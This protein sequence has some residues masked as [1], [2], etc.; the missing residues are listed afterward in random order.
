MSRQSMTTTFEVEV[1][2]FDSKYIPFRYRLVNTKSKGTDHEQDWL[3]ETVDLLSQ[4]GMDDTFRKMNVG[5]RW[6]FRVRGTVEL[7]Q[8]HWGEWDG[9]FI[10]DFI[11]VYQKRK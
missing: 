1:E 6:K 10:P 4:Y 8:D 7:C 5:D 11:R 9:D 2:R 3:Q